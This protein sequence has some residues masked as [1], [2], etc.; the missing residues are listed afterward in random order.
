MAPFPRRHSRNSSA[1]ILPTIHSVAPSS[2]PL[3]G[4]SYPPLPPSATPSP[5]ISPRTSFSTSSYTPSP[6]YSAPGAKEEDQH[7]RDPRALFGRVALP[8][9]GLTGGLGGITQESRETVRRCLED[10]HLN[11]HIFFNDKGFH[12][13]CAH[14]LLAA[15]S[16]GGSS[17]LLQ[18]ILKLQYAT[19]SKPLLPLVPMEITEKNW[20][21]HL[22]DERFYANYLRF[23]TRLIA[24]P[25]PPTSPYFAKGHRTSTV[26]VLEYYLFGGHGEMLLRS[27]SGAIHSLIHI[28][29]GVEFGLDAIVAEGLAQC[30]VHKVHTS[31]LFPSIE[32]GG[33]WPP[34]PPKPSGFQS[35]LSSAFSSL[36]IPS[37]FSSSFSSSASS[38]SSSPSAAATAAS[39][40]LSSVTSPTH[41]IASGLNSVARTAATLPRGPDD[42]R[43]PREGL[44]G[45]TI[46]DRILHDPQLAPGRACNIEAGSKLD[47]L[48]AN[49]TSS[50]RLRGWCDEW[51]FSTQASEGWEDSAGREDSDEE[52]AEARERRRRNAAR[53]GKGKGYGVPSWT[54]V[55]E[56][57]EELVWMATVI[58]AAGTRPGYK[59]TKLDFFLMHGLTSVLF[60]PPLLQAISP[61]LRPYLLVSHFRIL[62]AYYVSR[63]RPPLY[64][65]ETLMAA[66]ARPAPPTSATQNPPTTTAIRRALQE[67]KREHAQD[68]GVSS[69]VSSPPS[70]HSPLPSPIP[71]G[72]SMSTQDAHNEGYID[73]PLTPKAAEGSGGLPFSE[74]R[75]SKVDEEGLEEALGREDLEGREGSNPWMR[76]LQS[77]VDHHDEHVTKA[78]RSLFFAATHFGA[79]PRGMYQSSL[80]GTNEMDGSIFIRAAGMTLDSIG[81]AHEGDDGNTGSWD[82]SGLGWPSTWE[83]D[84]LLPGREWPPPS[85]SGKGKGRI[86]TPQ[87]GARQYSN[88][89]SPVDSPYQSFPP[90]FG[91]PHPPSSSSAS[92]SSSPNGSSFAR[93]RS[94]TVVP[95]AGGPDEEVTHFFAGDSALLS[96]R[97]AESTSSFSGSSHL[98]RSYG[99]SSRSSSRS[100]SPAP[101]P[102][103]SVE[104]RPGWRKVGEEV[105]QEEER[106]RRER[107]VREDE[108]REL[109]A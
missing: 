55:V 48:L 24:S 86:S 50:A 91:S 85:Y 80:P 38:S 12:N 73:S 109:M 75:D 79:S 87:L 96:P 53:K 95:S 66:S 108:E 15:Y 65:S 42:A 28:G 33:T 67:Y 69:P 49:E 99:A 39:H 29:Y 98:G 6:A 22:G 34:Q 107:L 63:G 8:T 23:F 47:D 101:S 45:F 77:A 56:K 3:A 10:N 76:V 97:L 18:D 44:S 54:E 41:P 104:A 21:D 31:N 84:E 13:H 2:P 58:Y 78:V 14:H 35:T 105:S 81:W 26:P 27:V 106:M 37:A 5:S 70:R 103:A 100:A 7:S 32:T 94:G 57:Y 74:V 36:R 83:K 4:H 59:K 11:K 60:L 72:G 102:R 89:I 19:A 61:H 30:A 43:Y 82:R 90:T 93:T 68:G 46:L 51:K 17:S 9:T 88:P 1:S 40:Y 92:S 71:E 52:D 64:V 16:L 62:L 20:A 25:P